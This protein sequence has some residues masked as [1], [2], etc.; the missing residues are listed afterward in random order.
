MEEDARLHQRSSRGSTEKKSK[1]KLS[2]F[3]W[4]QHFEILL[5]PVVLSLF[6]LL[7]EGVILLGNYPTF[8]LPSPAQVVTTFGRTLADGTLWNHAQATLFEVFAG[9]ALGLT[10]ATVLGYVLARNSL[11]ERLVAPYLVALQ[12]VPVVAIAPLLVGTLALRGVANMLAVDLHF[13]TLA[14]AGF[15]DPVVDNIWMNL[16]ALDFD[17]WQTYLFL[18]LAFSIGSELAPSRVDVQRSIPALFSVGVGLVAAFVVLQRLP[19]DTLICQ[20]FT[21]H[22]DSALGWLQA[23][24]NFGILTVALAAAITVIPALLIRAVRR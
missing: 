11:V 5:V 6:V 1:W 14:H 10:V 7:W 13:A 20:F 17:A 16:Q 15:A 24:L 21:T 9:L 19:P 4:R 3:R 2:R 23:L 22:M 18:Y 12:S 8:I